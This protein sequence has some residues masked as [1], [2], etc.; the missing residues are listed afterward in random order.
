MSD[1][2][3]V[4]TKEIGKTAE[5]CEIEDSYKTIKEFVKGD[6]EYHDHPT[7][8]VQFIVNRNAQSW[9]DKA[10]V[11]VGGTQQVLG[12]NFIVAKHDEEGAIVSFDDKEA[13]DILQ[14]IRSRELN[15]PE[16]NL[17]EARYDL[18]QAERF[19]Q[20]LGKGIEMD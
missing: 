20:G 2:V 16:R 15:D 12:G 7:L 18:R 3:R 17:A 9:E 10:T 4:I 5:I 1:K 6:I 14:D 19:A 11:C 8:G 13:Q